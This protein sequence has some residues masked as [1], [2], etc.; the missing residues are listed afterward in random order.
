MR[1]STPTSHHTPPVRVRAAMAAPPS[2]RVV[3]AIDQGTTSSR[4][5]LFNHEGV[6]VAT[7]QREL[8]QHYPHPAWVEQ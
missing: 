5:I 7:A 3:V 4:V 2:D 1:M 6:A 8:T